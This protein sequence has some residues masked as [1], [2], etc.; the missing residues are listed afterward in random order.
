M[1]FNMQNVFF[2]LVKDKCISKLSVFKPYLSKQT[3]LIFSLTIII[4]KPDMGYYLKT[5]E[6]NS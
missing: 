6:E 5:Y 1:N 3:G 4:V 2:S